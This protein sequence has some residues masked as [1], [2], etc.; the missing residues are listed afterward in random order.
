VLYN[1][2]RE[3]LTFKEKE[4]EKNLFLGQFIFGQARRERRRLQESIKLDVI[5][6][7]LQSS[8]TFRSLPPSFSKSYDFFFKFPSLK[9]YFFFKRAFNFFFNII[10][11][12][13]NANHMITK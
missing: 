9:N 2:I 1:R 3:R 12:Q 8:T 7:F 13:I 4:K 10:L 6:F 5:E 11:L